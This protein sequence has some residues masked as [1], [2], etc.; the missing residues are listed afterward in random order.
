VSRLRS[1]L[2][3]QGQLS[4]AF[5]LPPIQTLTL[6]I[7]YSVDG[8]EPSTNNLKQLVPTRET[9]FY[10]RSVESNSLTVVSQKPLKHVRQISI[11]RRSDSDIVML[12][13]AF[14]ETPFDG[15]NSH[16]ESSAGRP[17]Q[18]NVVS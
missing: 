17:D 9:R 16:A 4:W 15:E 3:R 14:T 10:P 7:A 6:N 11:D 2:E 12:S 1:S 13:L 18:A 8:S 5:L